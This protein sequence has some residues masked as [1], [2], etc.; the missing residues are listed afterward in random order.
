VTWDVEQRRVSYFDEE[1]E[2]ART[3][4]VDLSAHT[5]EI[6]GSSVPAYPVE[7]VA[8][9]DGMLLFQPAVPVYVL[10]GL[11]DDGSFDRGRIAQDGVYRIA[12]PLFLVDPEGRVVRTL[13]PVEGPEWYLN[14]GVRQIRFLGH[15]FYMA[16]GHSV[17]SFGSGKPYAFYTLDGD[18]GPNLVETG[19]RSESL[20]SD[21]WLERIDR[22]TAGLSNQ[23]AIDR[24]RTMPKP[25]MMPSYSG[26][27]VDDLDQAWALEFDIARS[28]VPYTVGVAHDVSATATGHQRWAIFS[29]GGAKIGVI[30][31][32]TNVTVTSIARGRLVAV[33]R[34]ELGVERVQVY[35]L[36]SAG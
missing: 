27:V 18:D 8:R 10:S 22:A 30:T 7:M 13:E 5:I 35:T 9:W 21:M 4:T 3:F 36:V 33:V 28:A 23:A 26:L 12:H 31:V 32:P 17:F 19:M 24:L 2:L 6:S 20:S 11:A 1:G 15:W 29:K 16:A 34:D 14:Q 25:D